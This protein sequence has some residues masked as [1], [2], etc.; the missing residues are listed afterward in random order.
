MAKKTCSQNEFVRALSKRL[1]V[2]YEVADF[3]YRTYGVVGLEMMEEYD[4]LKV[5]PYIFL[6]RKV[7]PSRQYFNVQ[8]GEYET[9]EDKDKLSARV[10]HSNK[11]Y[12]QA[13]RHIESYE[14]LL[15]KGEIV[16]KQKEQ[17]RLEREE[18]LRKQKRNTKARVKRRKKNQRAKKYAMERLVKYEV[19]FNKEE[20]RKYNRELA[21]RSK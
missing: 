20:Q 16:Q 9:T 15:A 13:L 12:S 17:Q 18:K 6:E 3:I 21:K 14:E 1:N 4:S 2:T 5:T 7:V 10:S 8:T 19:I 11:D